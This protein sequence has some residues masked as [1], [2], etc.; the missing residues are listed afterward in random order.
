MMIEIGNL[1][2]VFGNSSIKA[3]VRAL[4]MTLS[5]GIAAICPGPRF[6][7]G[8]LR[9]RAGVEGGSIM[10]IVDRNHRSNRFDQCIGQALR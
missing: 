6:G 2:V 4:S 3:G 8:G 10:K 1:N 5:D 9:A 7:A